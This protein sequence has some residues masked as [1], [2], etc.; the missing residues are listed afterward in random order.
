VKQ[1]IKDIMVVQLSWSTTVADDMEVALKPGSL[2]ADIK[3]Y[4]PDS[5]SVL[6]AMD[7][8]GFKQM[9]VEQK[10]RKRL[11]D[12]DKLEAFIDN[13]NSG[14]SVKCAEPFCNVT[15]AILINGMLLIKIPQHGGYVPSNSLYETILEMLTIAFQLPHNAHLKVFDFMSDDSFISHEVVLQYNVTMREEEQ[16]ARVMNF[17][18]TMDNN[19]V[20]YLLRSGLNSAVIFP[21][22]GNSHA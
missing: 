5:E 10:V 12:V 16:Y 17:I 1:A 11:L 22:R 4:L 18:T 14:F 7:F 21:I 13:S 8:L 19:Y 6:H 2:V 15:P 9:S 20:T 3:I